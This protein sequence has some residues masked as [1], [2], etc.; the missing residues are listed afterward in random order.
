MYDITCDSCGDHKIS[1]TAWTL[2]KRP[3]EHT[4][5][6]VI[7]RIHAVHLPYAINRTPYAEVYEMWLNGISSYR[8]GS[9]FYFQTITFIKFCEIPRILCCVVFISAFIFGR[10]MHHSVSLSLSV[11]LFL[12]THPSANVLSK[13]RCC[14]DSSDSKL[15]FTQ[16]FTSAPRACTFASS[17]T[18]YSL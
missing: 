15:S 11:A 6:A 2:G 12:F 5:A 18:W 9:F 1:E 4:A 13:L 3:N 16:A 7:R 17:V 8:E 14:P 10:P